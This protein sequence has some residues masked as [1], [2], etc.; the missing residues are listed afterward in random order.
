[1]NTVTYFV[2]ACF[3][4]ACA[5]LGIVQPD[6][7]N[8]RLAAGYTSVTA[9]RQGTATLLSGQKI[10]VVDAQ[11]I[12]TQADTARAG[13]DIAQ[14]LSSTDITSAENRLTVSLTILQGLQTYLTSRSK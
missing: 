6:T 10:T 2:L 1:M 14:G 3:M 11:N 9:V 5:Q 13:L 4:C 8:Q 7:F 12:Q